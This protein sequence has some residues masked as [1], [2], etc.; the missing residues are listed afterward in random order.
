[1]SIYGHYA[2]A[3]GAGDTTTGPTGGLFARFD[4]AE[5]EGRVLTQ[6]ED[7]SNFRFGVPGS[8]E[9]YWGQGWKAIGT[10]TNADIARVDA[11][12]GGAAFTLTAD[13]EYLHANKSSNPFEIS[14][15]S[16]PLAF[17]CR[18]KVSTI[19]DTTN[20]FFIGL[21]KPMTLTTIVPITTTGGDLATEDLVG[22]YRS[23]A[24]GD[25][26]NSVCCSADASHT[27]IQDGL[28]TLVADTYVKLGMLWDPKLDFKLRFF[29]NGIESATT[30]TV[31]ATAGSVFPNNV[32]LGLLIGNI[33]VATATYTNT[34]SWI[35]C[36]QFRALSS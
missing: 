26:I 33:A 30:H 32:R 1:M 7:F 3:P 29:V 15:T 13:N 17:E 18:V 27:T 10:A 25:E 14:R 8:T 20:D 35:K 12:T 9:T 4:A 21:G 19:A 22:F 5:R 2:G 24:D 31:S 36:S 6:W 28:T 23:S 11:A 34:V 16:Q